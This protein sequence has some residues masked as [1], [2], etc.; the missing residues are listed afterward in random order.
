MKKVKL[1]L[2]SLLTVIMALFSLVGC[3]P[4]GKY[5][6]TAY[7]LGGASLEIEDSNSYIELK[8]DKT[9]EI[10]IEISVLGMSI[11]D[12][13]TWARGD[14]NI[15]IITTESSEYEVTVDGD[16]LTYGVIVF[17]K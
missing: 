13:G 10:H 15:V 1:Y 9:A 3:T 14:G 5:T 8:I 16:T 11:N 17:K 7:K 12:S 4:I 6:A 2:V